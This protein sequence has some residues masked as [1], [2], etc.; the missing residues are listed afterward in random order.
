MKR[1]RRRDVLCRELVEMVDDYLAGE[2]TADDRLAVEQHLAACD[3]CR[4]YVQQVRRMLDLTADLKQG[5][6]VPQGLLDDVLA[7]Y[8]KRR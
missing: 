3:D 7:S 4:G 8:R 5:D 6:E 1:H 2:L